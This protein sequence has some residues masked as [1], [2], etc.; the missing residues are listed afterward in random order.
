MVT[1]KVHG[2]WAQILRIVSNYKAGRTRADLVAM[3]TGI[4]LPIVK[5]AYQDLCKPIKRKSTEVQRRHI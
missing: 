1:V 2:S 5:Q 3:Q 4:P